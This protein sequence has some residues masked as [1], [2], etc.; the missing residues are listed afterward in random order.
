MTSSRIREGVII[1]Q[2][3]TNMPKILVQSVLLMSC[4]ANTF[5][6]AV[7]PVRNSCRTNCTI[8]GELSLTLQMK[9]LPWK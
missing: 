6:I 4:T 8:T 2:D 7:F 5:P 9:S 1:M 3:V